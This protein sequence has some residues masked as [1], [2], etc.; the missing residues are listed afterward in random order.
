MALVDFQIYTA[1]LYETIRGRWGPAPHRSERLCA[2]YKLAIA[3]Q[4]AGVIGVF[5]FRIAT[6]RRGA[7]RGRSPISLAEAV[8]RNF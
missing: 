3:P 2:T 5:E 8:L 7:I 6:F 1:L 4:I